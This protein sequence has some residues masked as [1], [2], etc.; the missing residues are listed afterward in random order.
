MLHKIIATES[1]NTIFNEIPVEKAQPFPEDFYLHYKRLFSGG[2]YSFDQYQFNDFL[3]FYTHLNTDASKLKTFFKQIFL[4]FPSAQLLFHGSY[5]AHLVHETSLNSNIDAINDRDILLINDSGFLEPANKIIPIISDLDPTYKKNSMFYIL[6]FENLDINIFKKSK[7]CYKFIEFGRVLDQNKA[8][9]ISAHHNMLFLKFDAV[10]KHQINESNILNPF[11]HARSHKSY[12]HIIE[13]RLIQHVQHIKTSPQ[14]TDFFLKNLRFYGQQFKDKLLDQ[15][16]SHHNHVFDH[17]N[18]AMDYLN[19]V[20]ESNNLNYFIAQYNTFLLKLSVNL[21]LPFI[22]YFD[23]TNQI[24][25]LQLFCINHHL[26][27]LLDR[28]KSGI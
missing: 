18:Q 4:H 20:N 11:C 28:C 23:S 5:L 3:D 10:Y 17:Y 1:S 25:L 8:L 9:F 14:I 27:T 7:H 22:S 13:Q 15:F 19:D 12:D 16:N 6:K 24:P 26:I 2:L 21:K